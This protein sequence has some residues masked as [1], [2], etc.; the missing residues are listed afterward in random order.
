[1]DWDRIQDLASPEAN[2]LII[3]LQEE[4][5]AA[6]SRLRFVSNS[7]GS[8]QGYICV[9]S[10]QC[11]KLLSDAYQHTPERYHKNYLRSL[12]FHGDALRSA[13]RLE[14]SRTMWETAASQFRQP[15]K[16][17]PREYHAELS[18]ALGMLAE[19]RISL[20]DDQGAIDA[21][22][23]IASLYGHLCMSD[24][25]SYGRDWVTAL[26]TLGDTL[27][28][29]GCFEDACF[30]L[31]HTLYQY[32]QMTIDYYQAMHANNP[33]RYQD[34]FTAVLE[35]LV[36]SSRE[37]GISRRAHAALDEATSLYHQMYSHDSYE[38]RDNP[39]ELQ[40]KEIGLQQGP[41]C[42]ILIEL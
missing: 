25:E 3:K 8:I 31:K 2:Y 4:L 15:F 32:R 7:E 24:F 39:S 14:D 21:K 18:T 10:K 17:D 9:L 29:C 30:T 38:Q 27:R 28:L 41:A 33:I 26:C 5:L 40:S 11:C 42:G 37:A 12:L 36:S 13:N 16:N 1:M 19:A 34:Y 23:E 22:G 6:L 20:G 35:E